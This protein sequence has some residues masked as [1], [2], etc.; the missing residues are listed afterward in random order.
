[1]V[2]ATGVGDLMA[3][4]GRRGLL[5]TGAIVAQPGRGGFGLTAVHHDHE[6]PTLLGAQIHDVHAQQ[7]RRDGRHPEQ[8][9]TTDR[10]GDG[11]E[12]E[13]QEEQ[14]GGA[15]AA[16]EDLAA[17]RTLGRGPAGAR[18]L[19]S[20]CGRLGDGR[21][22]HPHLRAGRGEGPDVYGTQSIRDGIR[23]DV[24]RGLRLRALP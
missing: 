13:G 24:G 8:A 16:G 1:M 6:P 2:R 21:G 22:R 11:S 15:T 14:H 7:N 9:E 17:S 4:R 10:G 5:A 19:P 3:R 23:V 18:A 12:G 20:R